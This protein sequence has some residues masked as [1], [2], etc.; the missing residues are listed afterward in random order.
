MAH[1]LARLGAGVGEAHAEHH[2]VEPALIPYS[3]NSPLWS[4]NAHKERFIALPETS[5]IDFADE[6]GWKFPEGAVLVKTFSLELEAG[7]ASFNEMVKYLSDIT[8]EVGIGTEF[9]VEGKEIV[10]Q[11]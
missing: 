1:Q 10:V 3:V 2:V 7:S 5:P 6:G 11:I 4:D 9:R 8:R